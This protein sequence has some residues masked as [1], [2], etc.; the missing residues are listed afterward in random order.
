MQTRHA[1]RGTIPSLSP[2]DR[3]PRPTQTSR[4]SRL[5]AVPLELCACPDAGAQPRAVRVA[6]APRV[7]SGLRPLGLAGDVVLSAQALVPVP[8]VAPAVEVGRE[9]RARMGV[10]KAGRIG[11][12]SRHLPPLTG[13]WAVA[14]ATAVAW[15][16]F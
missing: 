1:A 14:V 4:V 9:V 16:V 12:R 5:H 8:V 13:A 2:F 15:I 7:C 10:L 3:S 6:L 11:L